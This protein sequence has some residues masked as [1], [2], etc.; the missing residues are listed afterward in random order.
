MN[1]E[2]PGGDRAAADVGTSAAKSVTTTE[3]RF[4]PRF[5][6]VVDLIRY[7]LL[8]DLDAV[9][10]AL[11]EYDFHFSRDPLDW[12]R[13]DLDHD[14]AQLCPVCG[15]AWLFG[16]EALSAGMCWQCRT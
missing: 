14:L 7:D 8:D 12:I 6:D 15:E 11:A 3:S 10:D 9:A 16:R 2:P 5:Y 4:Y 1:A 13:Q